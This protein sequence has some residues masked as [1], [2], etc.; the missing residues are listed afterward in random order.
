M[1]PFGPHFFDFAEGWLAAMVRASAQGGIALG[2]VWVACRLFPRLPPRCRCWL[3][4]L[5]L[6]KL[7]LAAVVPGALEAPLVPHSWAGVFG[8]SADRAPA[9]ASASRTTSGESTT[10]A[11]LESV[12]PGAAAPSEAEE[13]VSAAAGPSD[14]STVRLLPGVLFGVWLVVVLGLVALVVGRV[15]AARGFR[16]RC[17][18]IKDPEIL[19]LGE[20]LARQFGLVQPPLLFEADFCRSPVVFGAVRTSVVLPAALAS[21]ADRRELRLILAHEMAHIR[22]GD[23]VGNWFS[24][25]VSALF[26][27]H[28]LVWLAFRET[29]LAQETA[30]DEM[31]VSQGDVS[32]GD[33]GRLIVELAAR[34]RQSASAVVAVGVVESFHHCLGRRLT[35][36]R[37]FG[38][39]SWRALVLS[40]TLASVA[41][42][43]LLPW[44]VVA[45]SGPDADPA[46]AEGE[47]DG[48][49]VRAR[50]KSGPYTITVDRVH[51]NDN[52]R[53]VL[54][55]SGFPMMNLQTSRETRTESFAGGGASGAA[56]GMGGGHASAFM[57]PNL[58]LDVG[59]KGPKLR[60][61]SQWVCTVA[62]KVK[63]ADDKGQPIE[64]PDLTPMMGLRLSDVEYRE[65]P[66]RT[67]I[68]MYLPPASNDSQYLQWVEGALLVAEGT[69]S[70]VAFK[71]DE[72]DRPK[73][74]RDKDA[75]VRVDGYRESPEG[76]DVVVAASPP[77]ALAAPVN[78][79]EMMQGDPF[80]RMR[81]MMS[82]QGRLRVTLEDSNG[83]VHNPASTANGG[84]F[85][86][87][88][89]SGGGG[90][91]WSA[92]TGGSSGGRQWSHT[93]RGGRSSGGVGSGNNDGWATQNV[94]FA[95]LPNGTTVKA[96]ICTITDLAGEPKT[97]PFR[98]ENIPLPR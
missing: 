75:S 62:G 56:A 46:V 85:G 88:G 97:V 18:L 6:A 72:L 1:N 33:Y 43:G 61:K 52:S 7:L 34:Y 4:R 47:D 19:A 90:G 22:R 39:G 17:V 51:R 95:P 31:A 74:K 59:L 35:A 50:A 9:A 63:G 78:P 81:A 37:H 68:H 89:G 58:I 16:R 41:V 55:P 98:L 12:Q 2:L 65:G 10:F 76:I 32:I 20:R 45:Q 14:V 49:A 86:S 36:M 44:R 54:A 94:R 21:G 26:F 87:G 3:W 77:A 82:A 91:S 96:I 27:F 40:W 28:P 69:V 8:G 84:S 5:A 71:P 93:T 73:T 67:A 64:G 83:G 79:M 70:R 57:K 48:Q 24:T 38:T 60:G 42:L 11:P 92:T 15:L 29:R 25:I 53:I 23:L 30:C 66:G 80:A 13:P